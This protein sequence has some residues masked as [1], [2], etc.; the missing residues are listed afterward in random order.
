MDKYNSYKSNM[1]FLK[2][3]LVNIEVKIGFINFPF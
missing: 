2:V 3:S 1:R